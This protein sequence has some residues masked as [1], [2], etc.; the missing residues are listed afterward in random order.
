MSS[1]VTLALAVILALVVGY[2]FVVDRPQA[3]RAEQAKRLVQ[4]TKEEITMIT[5]ESPK[6]TVDLTRR[7]AAHWAVTRPFDAPAAS[8]PVGGLLDAV[9]G[10]IPQRTLRDA[11][12]LAA[13]GLNAPV[14]R[15][16]LTASAG[17][18][19]TLE[20]GKPAP[21][22]NALYARLLPGSSVY[23]V[24]RSLQDTVS[25]SPTDLRQKTL[26]DFA[27]ASVQKARILSPKGTLV[28]DR[29][30]PDRW[31]VEAAHPWPADDFK[32]TDMFFPLTTSDAKGF[33]DGV[34]DL[35]PYSLDHPAVTVDLTLT[36]RT[37]PLRILLS[38]K[39][40]TAYG[41]VEGSRI[42]LELDPS[43]LG[44]LAPD[45]LSL[46]SRR[47]LPYNPQN[48]TSFEW[49]HSGQILG[50]RRQGPVFTGGG[51]QEKEIS[52]MFSSV[53]FLDADKV[54]A[55]ASRPPGSPAF[56]VQTDGAQDARFLVKFYRQPQGGWTATD[57]ALGLEYHFA[58]NAL[59]GLPGPIKAFLG[60]EKAKTTAAPQPQKPPKK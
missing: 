12:D 17:R 7:D 14:A 13:Y 45:P 10:I 6:G 52:D 5:L 58:P 59:D 15:I 23:L 29:V 40:K 57:E 34:T 43:I 38:Q 16:T 21:V 53:G 32:V 41:T 30:G 27:N 19:V 33:H 25:K 60:L 37:E 24:D 42:I 46:V 8:F 54:E 18:S 31:R 36:G 51:L 56:E 22:G 35:A 47:I 4:L 9:L 48:L 55:L 44:K 1:R 39:G 2:I 28:V 20:I 3:Q 11:A 50:I 49:R 26:A